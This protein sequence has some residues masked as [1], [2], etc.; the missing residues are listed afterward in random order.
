MIL[1]L[2]N[3]LSWL[4]SAPM[5]AATERSRSNILAGEIMPSLAA[6]KI[7][8]TTSLRSLSWPL[9]SSTLTSVVGIFC[10][11]RSRSLIQAS[12]TKGA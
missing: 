2:S 5:V 7:C 1:V 10:L 6:S 3:C 4:G 8:F 12:N 11:I 9:V